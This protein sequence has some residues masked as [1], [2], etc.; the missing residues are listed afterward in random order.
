MTFVASPRG[1]FTHEINI[2]PYMTGTYKVQMV[3]ETSKAVTSTRFFMMAPGTPPP[4]KAQ[5]ERTPSSYMGR[6]AGE[7]RAKNPARASTALVALS[8][9]DA[10]AIVGRLRIH[11]CRAAAS[12]GSLPSTRIPSSLAR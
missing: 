4:P 1:E 9:G 3:D 5:A 8:G 2:I 11:R 12:C 10:G 6:V 7:C